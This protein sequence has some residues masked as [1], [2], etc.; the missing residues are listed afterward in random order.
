MNNTL[1][2]VMYEI[3]LHCGRALPMVGHRSGLDTVTTPSAAGIFIWVV[4]ISCYLRVLSFTYPVGRGGVH[5]NTRVWENLNSIKR[6][7]ISPFFSS[8]ID[9]TI[10]IAY[11]LA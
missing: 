3:A 5:F 11:Q 6:E 7:Q 2:K 9:K 4:I 1:S 10:V 8:Q